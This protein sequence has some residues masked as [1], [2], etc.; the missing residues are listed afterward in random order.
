VANEIKKKKTN[1]KLIIVLLLILIF[2]VSGLTYAWFTT[3][4]TGSVVVTMGDLKLRLS[5][6]APYSNSGTSRAILEPGIGVTYYGTIKNIGNL[7][8]ALIID[9]TTGLRVAADIKST[10]EGFRVY[11]ANAPG[12][13]STV[14]PDVVSGK[15]ITSGSGIT[16]ENV[17]AFLSQAY[18]DASSAIADSNY[19]PSYLPEYNSGWG[20]YPSIELTPASQYDSTVSIPA[21]GFK[22]DIDTSTLEANGEGNTLSDSDGYQWFTIIQDDETK[23]LLILTPGEEAPLYVRVVAHGPTVKNIFQIAN[24]VISPEP[25]FWKGGQALP[26]ALDA[27]LGATSFDPYGSGG[28]FATSGNI[29]TVSALNG[30]SGVASMIQGILGRQI[31]PMPDDSYPYTSAASEIG[32]LYPSSYFN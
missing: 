16:S 31:A 18:T 15:W 25:E 5:T 20:S 14:S 17:S 22:I 8:A 12:Y 29:T 23:Y 28:T 11:D 27:L 30:S 7:N 3:S 1:K 10:S 19:Y 24:L 26:G 13:D 21:N 32:G 6:F 9:P 4:V 2:A